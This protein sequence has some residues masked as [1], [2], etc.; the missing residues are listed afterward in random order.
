MKSLSTDYKALISTVGQPAF[1]MALGYVQ[2]IIED[3]IDKT[4]YDHASKAAF[5]ELLRLAIE[6]V[7]LSFNQSMSLNE[8]AE[9]LAKLIAHKVGLAGSLMSIKQLECISAVVLLVFEGIESGKDVAKVGAVAAVPV[10][11]TTAASVIVINAVYKFSVS[12]IDTYGKC[13]PLVSYEEKINI[14]IRKGNVTKSD[15]SDIKS[16]LRNDISVISLDISQPSSQIY[17]NA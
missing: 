9:Y 13:A 10:I 3:L 14:I 16:A 1:K 7:Q 17:L 4:N 12:A 11:G 8:Q 5:K 6:V 15:L 2:S